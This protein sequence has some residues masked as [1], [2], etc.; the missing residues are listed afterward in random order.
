MNIEV[1]IIP[2]RILSETKAYLQKFG[3]QNSEG[4]LCWAGYPLGE[5][6]VKITS[7]VFPPNWEPENSSFGFLEIGIHRAFG[8]GQVVAQ[9]GELIFAQVH[10][11][12]YEAFHSHIDDERPLSHR[13]GFLSIVVP[14]FGFVELKDLKECKVFE[15]L[16]SGRWKEFSQ[17]EVKRK[18]IITSNGFWGWCKQWIKT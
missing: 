10:S 1:I 15:Y 16:G 9:R 4:Y 7:C 12:P 3:R 13:P 17:S 14:Y 5:T 8:M 18:F 6:S 2:R 11:H